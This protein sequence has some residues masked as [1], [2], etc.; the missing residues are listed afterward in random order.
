MRFSV[1]EDGDIQSQ[2]LCKGA[3]GREKAELLSNFRWSF[4]DRRQWNTPR[5]RAEDAVAAHHPSVPERLVSDKE[6]GLRALV[7][8]GPFHQ[9]GCGCSFLLW[10]A[11][12]GDAEG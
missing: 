7:M 6:N 4:Q 3:E 5:K 12:V 9:A 2:Q 11:A 8:V 1:S 10:S